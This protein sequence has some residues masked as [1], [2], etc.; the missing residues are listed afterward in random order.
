MNKKWLIWSIEHGAWWM[1]AH[2]GYTTSR[3]LAGRYGYEAALEIVEGANI[4]L[5]DVPNEAMIEAIG[6]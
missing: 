5:N 3:D 2:N 1:P 4:G 6:E